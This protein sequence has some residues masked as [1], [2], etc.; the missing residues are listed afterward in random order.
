M[1]DRFGAKFLFLL[2][3]SIHIVVYLMFFSNNYF[4][5]AF[6]MCLHGMSQGLL[7]GKYDSYIYNVCSSYDKLDS[8]KKF[9]S[10]YFLCWDL[11]CFVVASGARFLL[12]HSG[13][14]VLIVGSII[15]QLISILFI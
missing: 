15:M 6:A 8:Y 11:A 9:L 1:F 3:R 7:F 4:V 13:Y 5:L 12:Q 2:S 10:G 14:S